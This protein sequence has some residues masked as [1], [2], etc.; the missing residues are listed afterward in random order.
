[1]DYAIKA[2]SLGLMGI[3]VDYFQPNATVNRTQF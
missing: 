1:M 3:G 2:C